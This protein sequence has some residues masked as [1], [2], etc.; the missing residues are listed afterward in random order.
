LVWDQVIGRLADSVTS[1]SR[2]TALKSVLALDA[3]LLAATLGSCSRWF[4]GPGWLTA[5]LA[6]MFAVSF[7]VTLW[8]YGYFM[9]R[10]PD[11]LRS[12]TFTLRKLEIEKGLIGDNLQGPRR[13]TVEARVEPLARIA[14]E[15]PADTP[16]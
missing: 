7:A 4:P 10:D 3:L 15:T 13:V 9:L 11:A 2:S 16:Q 14:S 5:V 6:A 1:G 12:E 8:S